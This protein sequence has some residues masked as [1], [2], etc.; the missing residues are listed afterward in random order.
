MLDLHFLLLP[1]LIQYCGDFWRLSEQRTNLPLGA[2]QGKMLERAG[3]RE[4]KQQCRSFPPRADTRTS[5]SDRQHEE[6][7]VD[8]SLLQPFPNLL[9]CEPGP[10][11]IRQHKAYN[12]EWLVSQNISPKS[13]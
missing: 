2:S 5:R 10:G 11:R 1:S 3:K 6:M 8:C 13:E 4:K 7:N 9:R 12:G